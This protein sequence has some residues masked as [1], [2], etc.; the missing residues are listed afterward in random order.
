M[1]CNNGKLKPGR[2][3]LLHISLVKKFNNFVKDNIGKHWKVVAPQALSIGLYIGLANIVGLLGVKT[4]TQKLTITVAMAIYA[5]IVVQT[6]GIVARKFKHL[7]TLF[8][9]VPFMFPINLMGDFT[10]VI[11][12]SL[13]LFGNIVAG[14]MILGMVYGFTK[15]A[16]VIIAPLLHL[17]FDI[18]FGFIQTLVFTTLTIMFSSN[19]IEVG[20]LDPQELI[21]AQ[22]AKNEKKLQK[23]A[24][25]ERRNS[26]KTIN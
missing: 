15:W 5:M 4:P 17:V 6:T 7:K 23:L 12:M 21:D 13:R 8:E 14:G 22:T 11:S 10:P 18:G 2:F 16:S 19:K 3:L 20:D 25:K 24:K 26:L 9:P 1:M